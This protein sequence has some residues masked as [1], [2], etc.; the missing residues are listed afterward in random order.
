MNTDG[1]KCKESLT[2]RRDFNRGQKRNVGIEE[3]AK[4]SCEIKARGGLW[5]K[6]RGV[7]NMDIPMRIYYEYNE[8]K[9]M[10]E[11]NI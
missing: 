2:T 5:S 3:R 1:N 11:N 10:F 6:F 9:Y 7:R 8:L 4:D